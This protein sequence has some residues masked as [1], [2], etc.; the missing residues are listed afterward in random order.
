MPGALG[1]ILGGTVLL[2]ILIFQILTGK[3]VIK[4][5]GATHWKVHRW[6]AYLMVVFALFHAAFGVVFALG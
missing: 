6:A 2:V 1:P 4:F 5:K 3:R